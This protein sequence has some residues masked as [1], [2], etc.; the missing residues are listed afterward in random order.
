VEAR[1]EEVLVVFDDLDRLLH[2]DRE[3]LSALVRAREANPR[4][5]LAS[6][7]GPLR[8]LGVTADAGLVSDW[9]GN[10]SP[11]R[12]PMR[13]LVGS[14]A[15]AVQSW[16]LPT[17]TYASLARHCPDWSPEDVIRGY[18][19]FGSAPHLLTAVDPTRS[20]EFNAVRLLLTPDGAGFEH[21]VR[22]LRE[23]FQTPGRYGAVLAAL[24][25][26][27]RTWKD[28]VD[29]IDD[30]TTG[31][32][33]APYL[34]RLEMLGL[35]RSR[36]S[37]DAAPRSR[38]TRYEIAEPSLAFWFRFVAPHRDALTSG[39]RTPAGVWRDSVVP[40]LDRHCALIFPRVCRDYVRHWG[41]SDLRDMGREVGALWGENHDIHVAATLGNGGMVYGL[42]HWEKRPAG[43]A[44]ADRLRSEMRSTRYG[45]GREQRLQRIFV[46]GQPSHS[47]RERA[48]QTP[49]LSWTDA[50]ALVLA[51]RRSS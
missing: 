21:P 17:R 12:D 35:V 18:C 47:L 27:A 49:E 2:A 34:K 25:Q 5:G 36:R 30:F 22:L 24:G 8:V 50:A 29:S 23:H 42:C 10:R 45:F 1:R 14:A 37:L 9:T 16:A 39:A 33:L 6:D 19:V 41:T 51:A 40:E 38:R 28:L 44:L 26:G 32:P 13:E 15:P 31:G 3:L 46:R 7:P 20:L 11:F 43:D 48:G 4:P